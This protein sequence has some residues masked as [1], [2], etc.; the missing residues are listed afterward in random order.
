MLVDD[1]VEALLTEAALELMREGAIGC[2]YCR[3]LMLVTPIFTTVEYERAHPGPLSL[4]AQLLSIRAE[5]GQR[6]LVAIC[7]PCCNIQPIGVDI[8]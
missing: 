1:D 4:R 7:G 6:A 3:H 8:D 5:F 2:E